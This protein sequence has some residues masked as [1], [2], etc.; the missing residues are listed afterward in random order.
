[1]LDYKV[2]PGVQKMAGSWTEFNT[3]G[4]PKILWGMWNFKGDLLQNSEN[5]T[6]VNFW[7]ADEWKGKKVQLEHEKISQSDNHKI[8]DAIHDGLR[9]MKPRN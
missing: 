6:L 5:Q 7:L 4:I 3:N 2:K 8:M 9:E 1:M